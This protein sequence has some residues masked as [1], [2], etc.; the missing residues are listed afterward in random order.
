MTDSCGVLVHPNGN[1][2][3]V[4]FVFENYS[5]IFFFFCY[6]LELFHVKDFSCVAKAVQNNIQMHGGL[7]YLIQTVKGLEIWMAL[8]TEPEI[9]TWTSRHC[10]AE[11]KAGFADVSRC[12]MA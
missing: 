8:G 5:S 11:P 4:S 6:K 9:F 10:V 7:K 1:Q 12:P 3:F 2:V